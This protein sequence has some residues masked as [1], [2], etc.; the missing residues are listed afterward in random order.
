MRSKYFKTYPFAKIGLLAIPLLA[1]IFL[2]DNYFPKTAPAG[3][4]SFIIAFEFAQTPADI[5]LL[6]KNI[7]PQTIINIDLGNYFDFGFMLTYSIFLGL[8]FR[9]ATLIFKKKWL[10]IGIPLTIIILGSDVVENIFLL[11]ITKIYSLHINELVLLPLL[12]KLH[13]ITWLKWGTLSLAFLLFAVELFKRS[14]LV[15][16]NDNAL[17][18]IRF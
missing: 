11:E 18:L 8:M 10:L 14:W 13:F 2:M 7:S 15:F 3:F 12:Q 4:Q 9:K 6:F 17:H 1:F 16:E 5:F